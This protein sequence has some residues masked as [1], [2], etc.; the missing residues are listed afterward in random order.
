MESAYGNQAAAPGI[1]VYREI[2][3]WF[4]EK[5]M[6]SEGFLLLPTQRKKTDNCKVEQRR[7]LR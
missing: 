4:M 3:I 6:P 1:Q 2:L 7:F 5:F